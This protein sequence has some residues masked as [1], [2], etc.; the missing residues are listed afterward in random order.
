[1]TPRP[2]RTIAAPTDASAELESARELIGHRIAALRE[3]HGLSVRALG[4][5][6]GV[7]GGFISQV[8]NGH[9][10]P[11]VAS[12][13]RIAAALGVQVGDLFERP[14]G[15]G[16]IRHAGGRTVYLYDGHGVRDEVI[17]D[18]PNGEIEVLH[19][20]ID[21][22][23][24][25]GDEVFVHGTRVEVVYVLSGELELG[26]DTR[27]LALR[28]GDSVTFSGEVPHGVWNRSGE[29]AEAIWI[30]APARY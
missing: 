20:R 19:T 6:A 16:Q 3:R 27:R 1:V 12:L 18:D 25:T 11:S 28:A 24:G 21:P 7:T 8:E 17:S 10:M 4:E 14:H 29:P 23:G 2:V 30:A 15:G 9:V 26:L 22:G 13:L 5:A